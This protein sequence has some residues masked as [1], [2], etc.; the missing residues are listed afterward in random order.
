LKEKEDVK[1]AKDDE[2]VQSDGDDEVM[3]QDDISPKDYDYL[4]Q[5]PLWSLSEE[6]V[7]ALRKQ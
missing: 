7:V 5:L 3:N 4:L 1:E 6:K 2:S